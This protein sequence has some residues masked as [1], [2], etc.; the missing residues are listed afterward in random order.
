LLSLGILDT[1]QEAEFDAA[2]R[3]AALVCDAP[4][5][6][7]SL[8][9]R[10]R[11]WFKACYGLSGVEETERDVAF[12]AHAICQNAT[13]V[14]PDALLDP[15]FARNPLVIDPPHVRF[16]AGAPLCVRG[17][18][19]GTL[20]VIDTKPG[21]LSAAQVE[22]LGVIRDRVQD[23]IEARA[24][25]DR[26]RRI[27]IG[28]DLAENVNDLI[29]SVDPDERLI[30]VNRAWRETLGYTSE[31]TADLTLD[32]V[33]APEHR[34]AFAAAR[35]EVFAGADAVEIET[36]FLAREGAEV[37]VVGS[38]NLRPGELPATRGVF[39][40]V[41]ESKRG[42]RELEG[43][44]SL[45]PDLLAV[46]DERGRFQRFNPAWEERLGYPPAELAERP[47][48]T[49]VHPRDRDMCERA[50][51]LA[52]GQA[53]RFECRSRT[54]T[55]EDRWLVWNIRQSSE[56]AFY[57]VARDVTES[58][59]KTARLEAVLEGAHAG[60]LTL[61]ASGRLETAN[62]AA[63]LLIRAFPGELVGRELR[64]LLVEPD[65]LQ[66]PAERSEV[67]L[68]Q[69]LP[70]QDLRVRRLDGTSF[71]AEIA[72]KEVEVAGRGLLTCFVSD[73]TERRA[74]ERMKD[75]LLST[76]S[77]ELRTPL[78]AIRGA[79]SLLD[80]GLVGA[81]PDEA[82]EVSKIALESAERLHRLVDDL[83]D[84]ESMRARQLKLARVATSPRDL[85]ETACR[86]IQVIAEQR[87]IQ[88]TST[89][90]SPTDDLVVDPARIVQVLT[91]LLGNALKFSPAGGQVR[92]RC[93]RREAGVRFAV[94]DEGP[95]IP[96]DKRGLIFEP[97]EQLDR[98][99]NRSQMS[100][101]GLGL[102]ICRQI[103]EA[104]GGG[105]GVDPGPQGI[106][107]QFWF[108]LPY[109]SESRHPD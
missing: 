58:R 51:S 29:Q 10:Q 101:S 33:I 54:Y 48:T 18:N 13:L 86:G 23:L 55:G 32:D 63:A 27:M 56:G 46:L 34:A 106:G 71:E 105:I 20:C 22:A 49:L 73:L 6:L 102:A 60:I 84:L 88:V 45:S 85:V 5:A 79:L 11:Q 62:R 76:V 91:N 107:S 8:V 59:L 16:Y 70:P 43:F 41:T 57:T 95:G 25:A 61:D 35:A 15:R 19:I 12:C 108:E 52:A 37:E 82:Q 74:L 89:F 104:H 67:F 4:I 17:E 94:V 103:V 75:E 80:S 65:A 96:E 24:L 97:F 44:F 109:H 92:L 26:V 2:V 64:D 66:L 21:D 38:L 100:G 3:A 78:T 1:P 39:R 90:P 28:W 69:N 68:P 72:L 14:V 77:H 81:L 93:E 87:G 83:L 98:S 99:D 9:D 47:L 36:T 7:V 42:Q 53:Q 31:Q 40:N 30:Y 50:L